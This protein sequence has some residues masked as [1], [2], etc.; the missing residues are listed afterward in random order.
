MTS[1]FI[2]RERDLDIQTGE[3]GKCCMMTEAEI[4]L[5]QL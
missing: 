2:K 1:I 4:E 5:I 3:Q